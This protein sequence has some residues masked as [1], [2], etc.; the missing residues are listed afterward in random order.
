MNLSNKTELTV[1]QMGGAGN[2]TYY[3]IGNNRY[4]RK[5]FEAVVKGDQSW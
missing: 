2:A 3:T 5:A 1:Q 4:S